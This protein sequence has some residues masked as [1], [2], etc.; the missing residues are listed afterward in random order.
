[1][2]LF[3]HMVYFVHY[4]LYIIIVTTNTNIIINTIILKVIVETDYFWDIGHYY[5]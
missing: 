1:M 5:F 3:D 4:Q 2:Q